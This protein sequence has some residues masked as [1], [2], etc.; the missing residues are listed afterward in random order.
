MSETVKWN[1]EY[2]APL[3]GGQQIRVIGNVKDDASKDDI[4]SEIDMMD[5]QVTRLRERH[6][7][8]AMEEKQSQ[9]E[10][11]LADLKLQRIAQQELANQYSDRKRMPSN[12]Q[13]ALTSL[14]VNIPQM[15][16]NLV[17]IR[18]LIAQRKETTKSLIE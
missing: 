13:S 16:E 3:A 14:E 18:K 7:I 8:T 10:N 17:L 11:S 9:L 1:I 5:Y 6:E 15:E 12:I 2:T 4:K